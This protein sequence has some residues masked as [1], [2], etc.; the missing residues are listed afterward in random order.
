MMLINDLV[1]YLLFICHSGMA[2]ISKFVGHGDGEHHKS[3][4]GGSIEMGEAFN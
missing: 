2:A 3:P 4:G 1:E